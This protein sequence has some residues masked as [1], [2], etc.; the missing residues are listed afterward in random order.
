MMQ[1]KSVVVIGGGPGTGIALSGL[2]RYTSKLTA[3]IST[4]HSGPLGQNQTGENEHTARMYDAAD[5]VRNSLLALGADSATTLIMAR[6]FAHR[7]APS[8]D[9]GASTFGNLFLSVLTEITGSTDLALQAAS[10][11]LNVRGEVLPLTLH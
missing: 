7:F 11:V 8:A 9:V 10:R 4:S 6:L 2:K 3:L 5:E 1:E